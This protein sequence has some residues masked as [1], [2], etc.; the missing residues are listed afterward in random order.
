[1][2]HHLRFLRLFA[3]ATGVPLADLI[4]RRQGRALRKAIAVAD[5]AGTITLHVPVY[6]DRELTGWGHVP[7]TRCT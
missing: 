5:D 4:R 2:S 1:M 6:C 3:K 7:K